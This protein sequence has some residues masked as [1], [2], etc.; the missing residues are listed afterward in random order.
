MIF[1]E[2]IEELSPALKEILYVE[3][4]MG[5]KVAET[6]RGWP[7]TNTIGILLEKPFVKSYNLR[8][9]EFYEVND[10][11]YWKAQYNDTLT[12]HTLA[13]RFEQSFNH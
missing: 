7:E 11:H 2:D 6:W 3:L 5:N 12:N 10:V 4:G 8:N 13:C 1:Q 9:I